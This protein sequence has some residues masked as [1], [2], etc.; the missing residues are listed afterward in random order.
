MSH[1]HELIDFTVSAFIIYED[2]ILLMHHKR[3]NTWIQIGGHVELHEDTDGALLREIEEECG[4]A[5]TFLESIDDV[6]LPHS[7]LL[8]RPHFVNLHDYTDTHK[9]LDLGYVCFAQSQACRLAPDE[10]HDIGWFSREEL[11]ALDLFENVRYFCERALD[12]AA[13]AR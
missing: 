13:K 4:L 2:K 6:Q 3:L 12:I 1:I 8:R 10:A 11:K 9:H 7:K 5:V